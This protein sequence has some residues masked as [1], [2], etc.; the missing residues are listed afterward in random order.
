MLVAEGLCDNDTVLIEVNNSNAGLSAIA[1]YQWKM[2]GPN[3]IEIE[4]EKILASEAFDVL[5]RKCP[6]ETESNGASSLISFS[7]NASFIKI[8]TTNGTTIIRVPFFLN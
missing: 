3:S 5:G 2:T 6:V 8:E 7:S 4:E 1:P